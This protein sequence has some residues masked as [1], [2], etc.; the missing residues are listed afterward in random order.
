MYNHTLLVLEQFEKYKHSFDLSAADQEVLYWASILHDIGKPSVTR[1]V[2]N[3]WRAGGHEKAGV[4]IARNL[5]HRQKE[6]ST[7]QRQRILDLVRWHNLPL[8]WVLENQPE[9]VYKRLATQTDLRLLGIFAYFDMKGRICDDKDTI[10]HLIETLNS[11][12]I[13]KITYEL[14]HFDQLQETYVGADLRK[15]NALWHAL[16]QED[17]SLLSK[18]LLRATPN[19]PTS[20]VPPSVMALGVGDS[21]QTDYLQNRYPDHVYYRLE[22]FFVAEEEEQIRKNKIRE[23]KRF[24]SV[25]INGRKPVL[26]D[27]VNLEEGLRTELADFIRQTGAELH[28]LFFDRSLDMLLTENEDPAEQARIQLAYKALEMP[29]PWEAHQTE[30]VVL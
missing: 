3:R 25:Y 1:W 14:D 22:D 8:W 16:K 9:T 19:P 18:L 24:L 13:P 29:H 26:L 12:T 2:Q 10:L 30:V 28:Y 11:H 15:K 27:G 21:E 20:M 17:M 23:V 7:E 6:I 4:P 5:L